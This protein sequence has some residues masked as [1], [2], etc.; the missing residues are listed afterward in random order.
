[1]RHLSFRSVFSPYV[2]CPRN[3]A[4]RTKWDLLNRYRSTSPIRESHLLTSQSNE[5]TKPRHA[6]L[7]VSVRAPP[8]F[9]DG[10]EHHQPQKRGKR[11]VTQGARFRNRNFDPAYCRDDATADPRRPQKRIIYNQSECLVTFGN[12]DALSGRKDG[13]P[14]ARESIRMFANIWKKEALSGR[15]DGARTT[16]RISVSR[17]EDWLARPGRAR[18]THAPR[19]HRKFT[20]A[21]SA[22]ISDTR[23]DD[24]SPIRAETTTL[25]AGTAQSQTHALRTSRHQWSLPQGRDQA[26]GSEGHMQRRDNHSHN[27]HTIITLAREP[28]PKP[29]FGVMFGHLRSWHDRRGEVVSSPS[30][31]QPPRRTMGRRR[32]DTAAETMLPP[33]RHLS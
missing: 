11:A 12:K 4:C 21:D 5:R 1:M 3:E 10:Y 28:Y 33:R 14:T 32:K 19:T 27:N 29:L 31:T 30:E 2:A 22:R 13:V 23:A 6:G 9:S 26:S 17:A 24:L 25:E 20:R 15:R 18:T 16:A 7:A 8:E